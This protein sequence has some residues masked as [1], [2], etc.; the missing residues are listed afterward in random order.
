MSLHWWSIEVR[1][2]AFPAAR[3]R[4]AH[5][6]QLV[7][8]A[9]THGAREWVW[10]PVPW[11]VI[12]EVAF[13]EPAGWARFRAL[14]GVGAALDAVPDPVAGLYV[15]PGRGG[16]SGS[17]DRRGP[18]PKPAAGAAELPVEPEPIIVAGHSPLAQPP[19][20]SSAA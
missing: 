6:A 3:W 19:A 8:A 1:D 5:G 14:P 4:D 7:E 18:R 13:A 2:G 20:I 10:T 16:S 15:Y 9:I 11:G 12:F 17:R